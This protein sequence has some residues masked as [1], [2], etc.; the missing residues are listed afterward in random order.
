[1]Q[2]T[3]NPR[4]IA[5][6]GAGAIGAALGARLA[7]AGHAVSVVA[8]GEHLLAM[9]AG[10]ITLRE[11][12][13]EQNIPVRA[14]AKV[15]DLGQQDVIFITLKAHQILPLLAE[16]A[17]VCHKDSVVLP[18][19]NGI[20]WW[21]FHGDTSA[22]ADDKVDG[23][24]IRCL[25]PAGR[26]LADLDPGHLL[27]CV[28]HASAEVVAPGVVV[29]NGQ[30]RYRI[31]EPSHTLSPRVEALCAL[32]REAGLEPM[33]TARIRDEI[34]MKLVGNTS[35]NPV[36]ALT[37]ARMDQINRNDGLVQLIRDVMG[38]VQALARAYGCDPLV[39]VE[40]RIAI[41]KGIGPV[42]VSTLQDLERG[43]PLEVDG[44]LNAPIELGQRAGV[45]MPFT[46][47]LAALLGELNAR[48]ILRED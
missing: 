11:K 10:G 36:G 30:H 7:L 22:F 35:Y 9:Q 26:G 23:R 14:V 4:R 40:E 5:I 37:R 18:A 2:G 31:G 38:E 25:D 44:I 16:V 24:R 42:K 41:A 20:P 3:S 27:G 21:Y 43:R 6:V 39:S 1:M 29:S 33:A 48:H 13:V 34:W 19:I 15:G 8:R 17:T 32:M 12:G 47:A 28:V 45:P 46:R